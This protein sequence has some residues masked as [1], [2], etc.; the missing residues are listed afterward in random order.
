MVAVA[1]HVASVTG[2][3]LSSVLPTLADIG[4][5][6]SALEAERT[7]QLLITGNA[8][9]PDA[10]QAASLAL[11]IGS[12]VVARYLGSQAFGSSPAGALGA[13]QIAGAM[14]FATGE[15]ETP[16][17]QWSGGSTTDGD[18][19]GNGL[20]IAVDVTDIP[21]NNG[22]YSSQ[23]ANTDTADT[24]P[25]SGDGWTTVQTLTFTPTRTG[26][27]FVLASMELVANGSATATQQTAARL[28]VDGT[29][30]SG[31]AT[32]MD[33]GPLPTTIQRGF[34]ALFEDDLDGSEHVIELQVNGTLSSGNV[35]TRRRAIQV[36]ESALWEAVLFAQQS[37]GLTLGAGVTNFVPGIDV[38]VP[39]PAE[40]R[41][42][43]AIYAGPS[44]T[45]FWKQGQFVIGDSTV[46]SPGF[47]SATNDLG[48]AVG[49]DAMHDHGIYTAADVEAETRIRVQYGQFGAGGGGGMVVGQD[50]AVADASGPGALL[51]LVLDVTPPEDPEPGSDQELPDMAD[52]VGGMDGELTMRIEYF[53]LADDEFG[54]MEGTLAM[55]VVPG[56]PIPLP[57]MAGELG[58]M[59]GELSIFIDQTLPG[60]AASIGGL[61]GYLLIDVEPSPGIEFPAMADSMG[62]VDG[63]LLM[64]VDQLFPTMASA[65]GGMDG[66]LTMAVVGDIELPNMVDM[67]GGLGGLLMIDVVQGFDDKWVDVL[68]SSASI[69]ETRRG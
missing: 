32:V 12:T 3:T 15:G 53:I 11:S 54:G 67:L 13:Q 56:E 31:Q 37:E 51:A 44:Q 29:P 17:M 20:A 36:Y 23:S 16:T 1:S 50:V 52:D 40:A 7:W 21:L 61:G 48:N 59:D 22:R 25:G 10:N 28:V 6:S 55:D 43:V 41:R 2:A 65:F 4:S 57:D 39:A 63:S 24:G 8:Y 64:R 60:M 34:L 19:S 33:I 26:A 38:T 66:A 42:L 69:F 14:L 18:G 45:G 68:D 58:S 62:G 35:N 47:G 46:I 30:V 49:D 9:D 5:A 27:H